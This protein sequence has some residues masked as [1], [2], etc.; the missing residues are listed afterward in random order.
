[1]R[2]V[3]FLAGEE[4]LIATSALVFVRRACQLCAHVALLISLIPPLS[5]S[6]CMTFF[7]TVVCLCE[8]FLEESVTPRAI[9]YSSAQQ[10][11]MWYF[12]VVVLSA[13]FRLLPSPTTMESPAGV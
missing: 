11:Y 10:C 3:Y 13:L 6:L 12:G 1:M 8:D 2:C 7:P 9:C 4:F 5:L